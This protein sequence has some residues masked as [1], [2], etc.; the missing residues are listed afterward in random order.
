MV[1]SY[2]V[3]VEKRGNQKSKKIERAVLITLTIDRYDVRSITLEM[4]T[5]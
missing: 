5:R 2:M 3:V 4:V 1:L